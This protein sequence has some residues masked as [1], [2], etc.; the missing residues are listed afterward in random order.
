MIKEHTTELTLEEKMGNRFSLIYDGISVEELEEAYQV[1]LKN[2]E[3]E[4]DD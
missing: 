4:T 3:K 1:Y 2:K